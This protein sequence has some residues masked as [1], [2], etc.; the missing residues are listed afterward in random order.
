M[1]LLLV[2]ATVVLGVA[3]RIGGLRVRTMLRIHKVLGV[4]ALIS[5]IT[6]ATLVFLS[7]H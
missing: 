6:H 5:G 3:R 4:C 7:F 1:T 2:A